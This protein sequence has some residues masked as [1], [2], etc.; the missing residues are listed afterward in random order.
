ME[1]Y[2]PSVQALFSLGLENWGGI[3][4]SGNFEQTGKVGET[5]TKYWKTMENSEKC[6]LLLFK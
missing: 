1:S 4:Q 3:F 5:H 2:K 6:Y